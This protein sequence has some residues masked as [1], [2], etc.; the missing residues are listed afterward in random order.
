[1]KAVSTP[2][3]RCRAAM[4]RCDITPPVGIYHRM[5]G[6]ATH[7]RAT[8]VHQPLLATLLHLEPLSG[9]RSQALLLL[10]L[11]HCILDQDDIVLMQQAV[12]SAAQV[13]P[14]QVLVTLSHTHA[15]G[16]MSRSRCALPGGEMIGPYLDGLAAKAAGLAEKAIQQLVP[17]TIVYG[18]GRS[19][20][21]A[22]RD[23][24]DAERKSFVC[25]YNPEGAADDTVLVATIR[26]ERA[27]PIGTLVNYA[28]H[29]TTLAWQNTLISPDYV[30]TLREVIER[31][32]N[33][34]CLFLQG[35]SG[36]LGPKV[37]FVGDPAV[38]EQNGRQ[39]AYA[40][41]QSLV[42]LP[43]PDVEFTYA[44]PVVSGATIGT[45]RFQPVPDF[46][47]ARQAE[48]QFRQWHESLAYRPDLPTVEATQSQIQ[49]WTLEETRLIHSG[50]GE[51]AR[52]YHAR[53]ERATRQLWR[54]KALPE[55][56]LPL[57]ITLARLGDAIWL[58]V[59]GEH[60]QCL[61]TELRARFPQRPIFVTTL[62]GGWQPG[63]IPPAET[64]GRGI[65]QEE[66]A[67]VARGSAEQIMKSIEEH[68]D[69]L[70]R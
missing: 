5:W 52:D 39:L 36:D 62:T 9:D 44:G 6:A 26:D 63:Y 54:L 31:E 69:P 20:L 29:P 35:A 47:A 33:A 59:A 43:H 70:S 61:Q 53:I 4:T 58:F 10:A 40:V 30:G 22:N 15:A 8:G 17:A 67:V 2:Q 14:R 37:G 32:T 68:L 55:G 41:L 56:S 24:F 23:Y 60:Y 18:F 28:C 51:L 48:W 45:W 25:G 11:D 21:A 50:E 64:Y 57:P 19:S 16:L 42:A 46:V 65:Y 12:A 3:T 38:A 1:M 27:Q 66:I 7:D 13:E 34:A 49:Q